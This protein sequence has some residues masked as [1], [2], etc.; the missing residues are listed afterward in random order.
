MITSALTAN[1][2]GNGSVLLWMLEFFLF[3]IWFWLLITVFSDLFRDHDMSGGMKVL[4]V[5]ALIVLPYLGAF[6]YLIV[7]GRGMAERAARQRD[8]MEAQVDERIQAAVAK[9]ASASDQI[10]QAKSLLDSG[11]INQAEFEKLKT[12]A[13]SG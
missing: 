6:I 3:V 9:P 12:K 7:R 4:W 13:L 5:I 10:A 1:S 8:A 2:V 11:A